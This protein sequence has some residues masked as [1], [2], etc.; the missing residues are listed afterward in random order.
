MYLVGNYTR[1]RPTNGLRDC[2]EITVPLWRYNR[3]LI[4]YASTTGVSA[5]H[6]D[7]GIDGQVIQKIDIIDGTSMS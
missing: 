1:G 5:V 3:R 4:K 6:R 7:V 2:A